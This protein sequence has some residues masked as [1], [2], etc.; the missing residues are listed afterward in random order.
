MQ[1]GRNS[2]SGDSSHR[3]KPDVADKLRKHAAGNNSGGNG[4]SGS[5]GGSSSGS[6]SGSG[7]NTG[8]ADAVRD[9]SGSLTTD[10]N[11]DGSTSG[12]SIFAGHDN[13]SGDGTDAGSD[14]NR[15]A[16]AYAGASARDRKQY[17][18]ASTASVLETP[19]LVRVSEVELPEG[20]HL[21]GAR[22]KRTTTGNKKG[23][24]RTPTITASKSTS[25][26]YSDI[27][28]PL[29]VALDFV[30]Q[31]PVKLGWG[32]HWE[33][34]DDECNDLS[35]SIK[36]VLEQFPSDTTTQFIVAMEKYIPLLTLGITLYQIVE[37]RWQQTVQQQR[38]AKIQQ[39]EK[40]R[41]A[42]AN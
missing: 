26:D 15:S 42:T 9:T 5:G 22:K 2:A 19:S 13:G 36:D 39:T 14:G 3:I 20:F 10:R 30:F 6:G 17:E 40:S 24:K 37:I 41:I 23:G 8:T 18:L 25:V 7:D 38:N 16:D 34:T 32:R 35:E 33:L 27:V 21:V 29:K 12:R 11:G 28:L 1:D 31:I 4:N